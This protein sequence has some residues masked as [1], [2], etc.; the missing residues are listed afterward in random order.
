MLCTNSF[1]TTLYRTELHK[2]IFTDINIAVNERY[3]PHGGCTY[4]ALT[5]VLY[6]ILVLCVL[7]YAYII[8]L[9]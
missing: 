6:S 5:S 9:Y 4:I 7:K 8:P 2:P 3:I 1:T